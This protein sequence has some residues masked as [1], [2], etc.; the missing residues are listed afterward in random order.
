MEVVYKDLVDGRFPSGHQFYKEVGSVIV[1][2]RDM[3]QFDSS[4]LVLEL[5]HLLAIHCH[6]RAL[7]GGLLHDLVDNQL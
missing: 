5:T 6:K 3:M 1:L 7:A 2:L 4:K